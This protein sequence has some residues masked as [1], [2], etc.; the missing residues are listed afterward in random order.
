MR[1]L[2]FENHFQAA[3]DGDARESTMMSTVIAINDTDGSLQR[4]FAAEQQ[5]LL[6]DR[7]AYEVRHEQDETIIEVSAK[8]ATALRA[9]LNSICKTLIIHEKAYKVTGNGS[10][11]S[12]ATT[13]T[14]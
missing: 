10:E 5:V 4:V 8:D 9:V 11:R 1:V 6:N 13:G 3:Y 14:D 12:N 7:A 2:W